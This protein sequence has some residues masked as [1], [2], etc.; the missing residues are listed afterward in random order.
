MPRLRPTAELFAPVRHRWEIVQL[1]ATAGARLIV[2]HVVA[3]VLAGLLPIV[4][5]V[6]AARVIGLTPQ[7]SATGLDSPAWHALQLNFVIMTLAFVGQQA[8]IPVRE[9]FGDRIARA[10]DRHE[11]DLLMD[12][13]T[14]N[15]SAAAFDEA[16]TAGKLAIAV[17][18]LET[19]VQSPGQACAGQISIL[20]RYTQLV[21]YL[22]LVAHGLSWWA[23][24]GLGT[25]TLLLRYALRGGLRKYAAA[26]FALGLQE[27]RNEYLRNLSI[28]NFGGK[29][30]RVFGLLGWLQH[31]WRTAYGAWLVESVRARRRFLLW[32]LFWFTLVA[33]V[34]S[35]AVF[36]IIGRNGAAGGEALDVTT[37][38]IV[39]TAALGALALG[40][41][42]PESDA[43]TAIG[44]HAHQSVMEFLAAAKP[45]RPGQAHDKTDR[46]D[47]VAPPPSVR[48]GI[49]FDRVAFS[50]P[51]A[52]EPTLHDVSFTIPA[53]ATTAV[54][55]V[56]G[57]GKTTLVKLLTRLYEPTS[58]AI[59]LDGRDAAEFEIDAWRRVLSVTFQEFARYEVSILDNVAYG[60]VEHRDD[61][62]GI[63]NAIDSVGLPESLGS[64]KDGMDT[65]LAQHI[66]GGTELSGGQWQRIA[67]ARTLFAHAHGAELLILD[68]PTASLDAHAEARFFT[69]LTRLAPDATVLLV[70][71]R[72]STVRQADHIVVLAEGKVTEQGSHDELLAAD[73][74][75]AHLFHTQ[76]RRYLP[77]LPTSRR[78]R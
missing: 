28:E 58:G 59:L 35:M 52:R 75:Y 70:S 50:Y 66:T 61:L 26:R 13:S 20:T 23:S 54:V 62:D 41:V 2:P 15:D 69:E 21:G 38:S 30:I 46:D 55:G 51:G 11:I 1:I 73:G 36:A 39:I 68:E 16:R 49:T 77:E 3:S 34:I 78:G 5:V 27:S 40:Q 72:F 31:R 12:A 74:L 45:A 8:M 67:L 4:F 10:V 22:A 44:M 6:A 64:L 37:F 17:R 24:V 7:A 43:A 29:E 53:G 9:V 63:Q 60:A 25:A 65:P 57:A 14:G 47:V 33:L 71:H 19:W 32:P 42:Y 48:H 18:E 76:A 56:N